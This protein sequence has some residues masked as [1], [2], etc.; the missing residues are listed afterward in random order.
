MSYIIQ[1]DFGQ[2]VPYYVRLVDTEVFE[3]VYNPNV[4]TSFKTKKEATEW[5]N[6]YSSM[7]DRSKVVNASKEIA[8][9]ED[10]FKAGTVRRVLSCINVSQSR[11]YNGESPK[12]VIEWWLYYSA[13][14]DEIKYEHYETWPKLYSKFKHLWDVETYSNADYTE[15][16]TTF[17]ICTRK[18]GVFKDFERELN[19]VM[20]KVTYKNDEGYLIFPITDHYLSAGG[21][22][23]LLLVNPS[24]EKVRIDGRW[25]DNEFDS[26][27]KA[28]NFMRRERYYE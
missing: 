8:K 26:L 11:S 5:V 16:Y 1:H 24:K 20:D 23:V 3:E 2:T 13:N 4:A 25:E 7:S 9:F 19:M 22:S 10:W 14:D 6:T 21:N 27:E 18:D 28:F 17:S 15:L 12:E